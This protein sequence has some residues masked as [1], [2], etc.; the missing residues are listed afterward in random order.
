MPNT[1]IAT[2]PT[3][4]ER[5]IIIED[6][7][8][9][10]YYR[11]YVQSMLNNKNI[12][13]DWYRD[14]NEQTLNEIRYNY[15][16]IGFII[17]INIKP[18]SDRRGFDI[19]RKLRQ[20]NAYH[21]VA[22]YTSYGRREKEALNVGAD[23][24]HVKDPSKPKEQVEKIAWELI[25]MPPKKQNKTKSVK[26]SKEKTPPLP[27]KTIISHKISGSVEAFN[28]ERVLLFLSKQLLNRNNTDHTQDWVIGNHLF[29]VNCEQTQGNKI[30]TNFQS[31]SVDNALQSEVIF[32]DKNILQKSNLSY[33]GETYQWNFETHDAILNNFLTFF[34]SPLFP[35]AK[36]ILRT[37]AAHR[38]VDFLIENKELN[39]GDRKIIQQLGTSGSF[40]LFKM[41]IYKYNTKQLNTGT[42]NNLIKKL[43]KQTEITFKY[44][45]EGRIN[46]IDKEDDTAFASMTNLKDKNESFPKQF[47]YSKLKEQMIPREH[48]KF[49]YLLYELTE[50]QA[51][52]NIESIGT[53]KTFF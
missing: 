29:E 39:D 47:Y 40:E 23:F 34:E 44:L 19:I 22:V 41:L 28:N 30:K 43:E 32:S 33:N 51:C 24:F 20:H 1:A 12:K 35:K 14:I 38:V 2:T 18:V 31:D 26:P 15:T 9:G 53:P 17:D 45:Y 13:V 5:I 16:P 10:Q 27:L 52:I 7:D 48:D 4:I 11:N 49:L 8:F 37:F 3:D 21:H 6:E 46:D 50:G 42:L 36:T 25:S